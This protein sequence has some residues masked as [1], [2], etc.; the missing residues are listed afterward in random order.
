MAEYDALDMANVV[1]RESA[2]KLYQAEQRAEALNKELGDAEDLATSETERAMEL[3]RELNDVKKRLL[4]YEARTN[5]EDPVVGGEEGGKVSIAPADPSVTGRRSGQP[6]AES[7]KLKPICAKIMDDEFAASSGDTHHRKAPTGGVTEPPVFSRGGY[8]TSHHTSKA[9]ATVPSGVRKP[10]PAAEFTNGMGGVSIEEMVASK[11]GTFVD[12]F[13]GAMESRIPASPP[14]SVKGAGTRLDVYHYEW[15]TGSQ[16]PRLG[17]KVKVDIARATAER[18][19]PSHPTGGE[20]IKS[21]CKKASD[22]KLLYAFTDELSTLRYPSH[23]QHLAQMLYSYALTGTSREHGEALVKNALI[24]S[25]EWASR[26]PASA[27]FTKLTAVQGLTSLSSDCSADDLFLALD[28]E[29]VSPSKMVGYNEY[30]QAGDT[31]RIEDGFKPSQAFQH[32]RELASRHLGQP[33][34]SEQVFVEA[35]CRFS[36]LLTA[37]RERHPFLEPFTSKLADPEF[38]D[39][40][41]ANPVRAASRWL[42]VFRSLESAETFS[43]GFAAAIKSSSSKVKDKESGPR[44]GAAAPA[45]DDPLPLIAQLLAGSIGGEGSDSNAALAKALAAIKG[46][47]SGTTP[48]ASD[49]VTAVVAEMR[50]AMGGDG[51]VG[52]GLSNVNNGGGR[53]PLKFDDEWVAQHGVVGQKAPWDNS[54]PQL[55]TAKVMAKLGVKAEGFEMP[56]A[57]ELA[58]DRCPFCRDRIDEWF[59]RPGTKEFFDNGSRVRPPGVRRT[60]W[61]H[62]VSTCS[63]MYEQLHRFV[64]ANPA[65]VGLFNALPPGQDHRRA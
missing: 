45:K 55:H 38:S 35:S 12:K 31:V 22:E 23:R 37:Q 17:T 52:S 60:G 13:V 50:Q 44:R 19:D 56:A 42:R 65:E 39:M 36:T 40:E 27:G 5:H 2:I 61:H 64:K 7:A 62:D 21:L 26:K 30:L 3:E 54:R 58:G 51:G 24:G 28:R 4:Y 59:Y 63:R 6:C 32:L 10:L 49:I 34:D 20:A 43:K 57:G 48:S 33:L 47:D 14:T 29:F 9:E 15:L 1:L 16:V 18:P 46:T 25:L 11:F 53:T 41:G 8:G